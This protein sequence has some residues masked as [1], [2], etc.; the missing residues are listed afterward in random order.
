MVLTA[1]KACSIVRYRPVS[2]I[3]K[4]IK[5]AAKDGYTSETFELTSI[6]LQLIQELGY[7]VSP[8]SHGFYLVKW[9]L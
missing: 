1:V 7:F 9:D 3:L 4:E 6:Q 5:K 8:D 2:K